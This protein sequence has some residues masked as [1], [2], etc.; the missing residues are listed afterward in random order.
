VIGPSYTMISRIP[1]VKDTYFQHKVLTC[2]HGKPTYESLQTVLTESK[3]NAT[4]VPSTLGGGNN[5]HLGLLLSTACYTALANILPWVS[6]NNP[7]PFAPPEA[8]TGPQIEAAKDVWKERKQ[9]FKLNQATEKCSSRKWSKPSI[10]STFKHCSI[11]PLA[12]T[13]PTFVLFSSISFLPTAESRPSRSNP[14]KRNY[15]TCIT[16]YLN[17]LILS[18]AASMILPTLQIMLVLP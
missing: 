5:G 8:G 3:A 9:I 1:S 16:T 2:T 13:L 11:A 7:G 6:P 17:L 10:R 12:T 18:S 14:K 4:S 15:T